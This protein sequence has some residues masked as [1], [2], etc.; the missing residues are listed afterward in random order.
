MNGPSVV[1]AKP[2]PI[3]PRWKPFA[4]TSPLLLECLR[5]M[6]IAAPELLEDRDIVDA[7]LVVYLVNH[8]RF[9][10]EHLPMS[11]KPT[12]RQIVRTW[13][14][15]TNFWYLTNDPNRTLRYKRLNKQRTEVWPKLE[16]ALRKLDPDLPSQIS[17]EED[18]QRPRMQ[19]PAIKSFLLCITLL[20]GVVT[21]RQ[22]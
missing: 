7:L 20:L 18:F 10:N 16:T 5:P 15:L 13:S 4:Y 21:R 11:R 1:K 22:K 12:D 8:S 14:K 2:A 3:P 19:D 17:P 9:Q 6:F